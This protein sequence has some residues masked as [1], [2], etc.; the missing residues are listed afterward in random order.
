MLMGQGLL[1][2]PEGS[3]EL[4]HVTGGRKL[5][6]AATFR[7]TWRVPLRRN[8]CRAACVDLPAEARLMKKGYS[9]STVE[10]FLLP[11]MASPNMKLHIMV[12]K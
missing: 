8:C 6:I 9:R 7:R 5:R 3:K 1:K 11:E 2:L 12:T 10:L 4:L